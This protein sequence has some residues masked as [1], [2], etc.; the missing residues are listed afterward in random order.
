MQKDQLAGYHCKDHV[1]GQPGNKKEKYMTK[2]PLH[3]IFTPKREAEDDEGGSMKHIYRTSI[4][5]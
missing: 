3:R 4:T 2:R 5:P 1:R